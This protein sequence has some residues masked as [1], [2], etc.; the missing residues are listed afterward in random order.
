M[1]LVNLSSAGLLI[2]VFVLVL[3]S[4][5]LA[6]GFEPIRIEIVPTPTDGGIK[7]DVPVKYRERFK[8]WK[9]ELLSTEIGRRQ[10]ETYANNKQFV[11]TIKISR[12]VGK[13]AGTGKYQWDDEG[14]FVGAT[15]TLGSGIDEGYPNAIYYPVLNSLSSEQTTHQISGNI[16]AAT[17]MSH[18]IGHVIQ[19]EKANMKQL[20]AQF[21]LIPVYA[22]IFLN[23]GRNTHDQKLVELAEKIGGTPIEIWESREYLSE[24]NAMHFLQQRIKG[25]D[26]YCYVFNRI[27]H[28]VE[29]Y[30]RAYSS[31]FDPPAAP[32]VK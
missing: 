10:W 31:M 16:L 8:Q 17:K 14:R 28:N 27:R 32:C 19:T 3:A 6:H 24:V 23:N 26:F 29:T 1:N 9:A 30:A 5:V 25:E 12:S 21:E 15:I 4:N 11:L 13:G 18:E 22:S 2:S 20:Q 7:E